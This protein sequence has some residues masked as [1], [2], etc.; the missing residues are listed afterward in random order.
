[1]PSKKK[2]KKEEQKPVTGPT[3]TSG[4]AIAENSEPTID[5]QKEAEK[6][7]ECPKPSEFIEPK[8]PVES[9]VPSEIE[10]GLIEMLKKGPVS[11]V[12][13]QA[14]NPKMVGA[15]GR[16]CGKGLVNISKKP[17]LGKG[18]FITLIPEKLSIVKAP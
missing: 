5:E 2:S 15:A 4:M 12:D 1:M 3:E 11:F 7:S 6:K 10:T 9:Y 8:I 13:L 14:S 17:E 18:K 16:L